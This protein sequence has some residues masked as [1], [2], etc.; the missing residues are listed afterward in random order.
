M[1]LTNIYFAPAQTELHIFA[2]NTPITYTN[3]KML[4]YYTR[5]KG[6]TKI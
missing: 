4:S 6:I 1:K 2:N 3:N 5:Q